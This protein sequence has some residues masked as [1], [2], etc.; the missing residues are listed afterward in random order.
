MDTR[1]EPYVAHETACVEQPSTIGPRTRI[2]RFAHVKPG[3]TIGAD[4]DLGPGAV[5]GSTAVVGDGVRIGRHVVVDDGVVLEDGVFCGPGVVLAPVVKPRSERLD[6]CQRLPIVVRRGASLGA[7][8]TVIGGATVGEYAMVEAGSVVAGDVPRYGVAA[9]VP[10]RQT[11]WLCRCTSSAL[12][13]EG[14][15]AACCP[16]CG[17][18]YRLDPN[19]GPY[20]DSSE[21][22]Q[23]RDQQRRLR[24]EAAFRRIAGSPGGR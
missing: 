22:E 15:A 24:Q 4:C 2:G 1:V 11:G 6:A 8:A 3:A 17:R 21:E 19:R 12:S 18:R 16:A 10:A 23:A 7:N 20:E 5:V 14:S 9:G 13:F